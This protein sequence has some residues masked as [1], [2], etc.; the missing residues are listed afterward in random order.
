MAAPSALNS[1]DR[2]TGLARQSCDW[3]RLT[4]LNKYHSLAMQIKHYA[5]QHVTHSLARAK[6]R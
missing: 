3:C 2:D 4:P 1:R 5:I 6:S